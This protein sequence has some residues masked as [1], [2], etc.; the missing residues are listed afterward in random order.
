MYPDILLSLTVK[1]FEIWS[2]SYKKRPILTAVLTVI[3]AIVLAFTVYEINL[4]NEEQRKAAEAERLANLDL[5]KQI[6]E[7]DQVHDSLQNLITF[8]ESQR[9]KVA[10]EQATIA[11]LS[12][13]RAQLEPIVKQDRAVIDQILSLQAQKQAQ[14]AEKD[15]WFE[16]GFGFIAG[17]V[18][19]MVASFLYALLI[20]KRGER[21]GRPPSSTTAPPTTP[22]PPS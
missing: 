13:E 19:S 16:R 8:V 5:N 22:P 3:I 11:Q 12:Q 6:Q 9:T 1:L 4:K 7:L 21:I 17:V 10:V 15:K 18:G 2:D 20:A 14:Q